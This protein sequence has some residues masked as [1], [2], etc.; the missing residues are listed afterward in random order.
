MIIIDGFITSGGQKM[1]KSIGNVINPFDLVQEYGAEALRYYVLRE[2]SP[3]E[4]TDMTLEGFKTAYNANLANGL[5]NLVSRVMKL[6]STHLEAP[7]ALENRGMTH[8]YMG[9]ME[10]FNIQKAAESI[11][12]QIGEI[13]ARIQSE[14]PFKVI[15]EDK[16]KGKA[17]ITKLVQDI[18]WIAVM[19]EPMLPETSQTIQT[20]V[21]ENKMPEKPLFLRKD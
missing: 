15:K 20:L 19:L 1:S 3:F 14:Q 13:D 7:V 4:D 17:M 10:M 12:H 11:W 16:E 9:A 5:G 6:A 2:L 18:H 21:K 8:E